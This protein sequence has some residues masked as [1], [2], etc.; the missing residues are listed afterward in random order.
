[1]ALEKSLKYAIIAQELTKD[2]NVHYHIFAEFGRQLHV[3]RRE[4]LLINGCGVNIRPVGR[5]RDDRVNSV[6]Y[7]RKGGDFI[8]HGEFSLFQGYRNY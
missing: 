8:E 5:K 3:R 2:D 7:L 4:K 6:L 1:M